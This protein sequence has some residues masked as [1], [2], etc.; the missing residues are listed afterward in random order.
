MLNSFFT[1]CSKMVAIWT[2]IA[3][4]ACSIVGVISQTVPPT[5]SPD[6]W[7]NFFQQAKSRVQ[8]VPSQFDGYWQSMKNVGTQAGQQFQAFGSQAGQNFK[9]FGTETA[10]KF[11][12]FGTQTA[13]GAVNATRQAGDGFK[14]FATSAQ[15]FFAKRPSTA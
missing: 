2:L 13:D 14:Q 12:N 11:R 5:A 8:A 4:S 7:G 15:S 10:S 3:L 6:V 1:H 9:T